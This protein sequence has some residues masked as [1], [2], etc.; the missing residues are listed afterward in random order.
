[1]QFTAVSTPDAATFLSLERLKF[2]Q[3]LGIRTRAC[4]AA[5]AKV[6]L[7]ACLPYL[8]ISAKPT[9]QTILPPSSTT[10]SAYGAAH[11]RPPL[12]FDEYI[13]RV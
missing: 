2:Y 6:I 4:T 8:T 5:T 3:N 1:M 12:C 13:V 7:V 9:F 11:L 10:R